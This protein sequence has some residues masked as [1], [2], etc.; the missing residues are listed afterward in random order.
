MGYK[1]WKC[2]QKI[3][4]FN[5][6]F[7]FDEAETQQ[8]IWLNLKS[9]WDIMLSV[10]QNPPQK[11]E[12]SRQTHHWC[13]YFWTHFVQAKRMF[14][15][16]QGKKILHTFLRQAALNI[17]SPL[18]Y[19]LNW[20]FRLCWTSMPRARWELPT[21]VTARKWIGSNLCNNK[22]VQGKFLFGLM[23]NLCPLFVIFGD[24]FFVG[25]M[26]LL[27]YLHIDLSD[28]SFLKD[29]MSRFT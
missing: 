26:W 7:S 14:T 22:T 3:I 23:A 15:H 5:F 20:K 12:L 9:S 27:A 4:P 24:N 11:S 13:V 8:H 28:A 10:L 25:K 19:Y 18:W 6:L 17:I 1:K 16:S 29:A 21:G 2:Y